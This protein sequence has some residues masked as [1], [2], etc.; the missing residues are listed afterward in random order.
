MR[1]DHYL[2]IQFSGYS[3]SSFG[4]H[5]DDISRWR[6][7]E[8]VVHI[9]VRLTRGDTVHVFCLLC[10]QP[11]PGPKLPYRNTLNSNVSCV[12]SSGGTTSAWSHINQWTDGSWSRRACWHIILFVA[13]FFSGAQTVTL[14][15][16]AN[17]DG[18]RVLR[19]QGSAPRV[20]WML[21]VNLYI[22]WF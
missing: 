13:N 14:F 11:S 22:M 5:P 18:T 21:R 4:T 19:G 2:W 16:P 7:I 17:V 12:S 20:E 1:V 15:C 9:T 6:L 3:N 10:S 8:T